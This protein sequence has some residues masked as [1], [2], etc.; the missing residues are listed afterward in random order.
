MSACRRLAKP[1]AL[2]TAIEYRTNIRNMHKHVRSKL[3]TFEKFAAP[4]TAGQD[5]GWKVGPDLC[6]PPTHGRKTSHETRTVEAQIL[7]P[8]H[9]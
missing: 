3:E 6:V 1:E 5:I 8:R 4:V 2:S 7:G 9:P